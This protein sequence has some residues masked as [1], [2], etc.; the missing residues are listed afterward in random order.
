MVS[1]K[2]L[3]KRIIK[4]SGI[5][6]FKASISFLD[7]L[8]VVTVVRERKNAYYPIIRQQMKAEVGYHENSSNS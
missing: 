5:Q 4:N 7:C 6:I 1:P 8:T 3:D 2:I